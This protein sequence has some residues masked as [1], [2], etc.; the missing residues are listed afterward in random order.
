M[1]VAGSIA[2]SKVAMIFLLMA[3]L[4]SPVAG[5]VKLTMGAVVSGDAAVEKLHTKGLANAPPAG[6]LAPVEILALN[7]VLLERLPAGVKVAVMDG[8]S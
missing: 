2:S 3:T 4:V 8:S 6:F 1:I 5:A 7:V